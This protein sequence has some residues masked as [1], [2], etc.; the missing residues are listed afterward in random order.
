MSK[1]FKK[2]TSIAMAGVMATSMA[3]AVSAATKASCPP[4]NLIRDG[5]TQ[6]YSYSWVHTFPLTNSIGEV[7]YE[8]CGKTE[9]R[10]RYNWNCTKCGE[11]IKTETLVKYT[12]SNP[13]CPER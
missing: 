11:T 1:I 8:Q 10:Y 4:H 6:I 12:H 2:I 7:F 3:V 13:R 9:N 5:G